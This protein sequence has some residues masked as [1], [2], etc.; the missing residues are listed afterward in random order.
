MPS[1]N[2]YDVTIEVSSR[3]ENITQFR[4]NVKCYNERILGKSAQGNH[5]L[6]GLH[7]L[8]CSICFDP[9][10]RTGILGAAGKSRENR[11]AASRDIG[12]FCRYA[13]AFRIMLD[14][15]RDDSPGPKSS[16]PLTFVSSSCIHL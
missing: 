9:G 1:L 14:D 8:N 6:S 11:I 2:P 15:R 3:E 13:F 12:V 4:C 5:I 16:S 7:N 10:S